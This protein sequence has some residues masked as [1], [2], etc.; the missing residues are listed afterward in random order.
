MRYSLATSLRI[1]VGQSH[2][3][4]K[5][6]LNDSTE[7]AIVGEMLDREL[8]QVSILIFMD[9]VGQ[10][11]FAVAPRHLARRQGLYPKAA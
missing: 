2:L 11:D 8:W 10:W 4:M 1:C 7:K 3:E 9:R 5:S 6:G